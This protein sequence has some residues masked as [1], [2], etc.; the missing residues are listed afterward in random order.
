[1]R[2]P[3]KV[4]CLVLILGIVLF[5]AGDLLMDLKDG[6]DLD[7]APQL[8]DLQMKMYYTGIAIK[9]TSIPVC[10]AMCICLA[11]VLIR[12]LIRKTEGVYART[13]GNGRYL[14]LAP[15][16]RRRRMPFIFCPDVSDGAGVE[17]SIRTLPA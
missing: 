11:V 10:L 4:F 6:I 2:P 17:G 8:F 14:R 5:I 9:N 13:G 1:M 7:S 16:K 3:A 15:A 12:R